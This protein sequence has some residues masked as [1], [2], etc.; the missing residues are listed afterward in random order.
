MSVCTRLT[1]SFLLLVLL[2]L[3]VGMSYLDHQ[4]SA[5]AVIRQEA[6]LAHTGALA[7]GILAS[8]CARARST[9]EAA[10]RASVEQ[11]PGGAPPLAGLL[12]TLQALA[13]QSLAD[14]VQ[15]REVTGR[16]VAQVGE[17]PTTALDCD[18]DPAS[19]SGGAFLSSRVP[20]YADSDIVGA[21]GVSSRLD[22]AFLRRIAQQVGVVDLAL[23]DQLGAV[24]AATTMQTAEVLAA[25]RTGT[26]RTHDR[27]AVQV[28]A[29]PGQPF[30]LLLVMPIAPGPAIGWP[31]VLCGLLALALAGGLALGLARLSARPIVALRAALV[32]AHHREL[33]VGVDRLGDTLSGTHDLD[34][35]LAVVLETVMTSTQARAGMVLLLSPGQEELVV[36]VQRGLNAF[37]LRPGLSL[38]LTEGVSGQVA[39]LG[40]PV[41]GRVGSGPDQL[42]LG[43]QEPAVSTVLCL[44]L[45]CGGHTIGVLNLYDRS[46]GAEFDAQDLS[47][48]RAFMAQ[49]MVAVENVWSHEEAQ[50]LSS[51]DGLTGLW[52]HRHL[53][54]LLGREME[55]AARFAHPVAVLMLD[56]D[57]FKSVNDAFGHQRG[58][59]VLVELA[60]RVLNQ[61]R[62]VDVVARYGGEELVVLLPETDAASAARTAQRICDAV[63]SQPFGAAGE[64]PV[65]VT[66]SAGVAVFPAHGTTAAALL[67][68]AD[69]AMYE[70]KHAG[71]DQ[72]Q[73]ASR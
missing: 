11:H 51:T 70:A 24:V 41:H 2:P 36:S 40:E 21:A 29:M 61:V 17:L 16:V 54:L 19:G 15:I 57:N 34:R 33:Q 59:A 53:H 44:P 72:W 58:D 50:R 28:E 22:Q 7:A 12:R 45:K 52:N 43:P 66:V 39:R 47:T 31:A 26:G 20:R 37:M 38:P 6:H 65:G 13:G 67:G 68:R 3:L 5:A 14:G 46:D 32:Q 23:L 4:R 56:L 73:V 62:E 69:E 60:K 25:S 35:I 49:A 8:Y 71:R 18:H 10:A 63:R 27:I 9:A 64:L 55:R 42:Q 30:G 48:L 1:A